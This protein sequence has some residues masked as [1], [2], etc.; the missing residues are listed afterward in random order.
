MDPLIITLH[1]SEIAE[2][3]G[4]QVKSRGMSGPICPLARKMVSDGHDPARP[5]KVFR[6]ETLCFSVVSLGWWASK[7][8]R[9]SVWAEPK[10]YDYQEF[11]RAS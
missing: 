3:D 2:F 7:Q 9:E 11:W 5:V 8:C 10:V 6:G 4:T 1:G